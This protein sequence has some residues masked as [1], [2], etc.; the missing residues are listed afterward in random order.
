MSFADVLQELTMKYRAVLDEDAKSGKRRNGLSF[1]DKV[2]A[3]LFFDPDRVGHFAEGVPD[4]IRQRIASR[5]AQKFLRSSPSELDEL[6]AVDV[7]MKKQFREG[8]WTVL[9]LNLVDASSLARGRRQLE[10]IEQRVREALDYLGCAFIPAME[11]LC[12]DRDLGGELGCGS[13]YEYM[14]RNFH[15]LRALNGGHDHVPAEG[16]ARD[17]PTLRMKFEQL[18]EDGQRLHWSIASHDGRVRMT[19]A[20]LRKR[21]VEDTQAFLRPLRG[22]IPDPHAILRELHSYASILDVLAKAQSVGTSVFGQR[23][24][25]IRDYDNNVAKIKDRDPIHVASNPATYGKRQF[26]YASKAVNASRPSELVQPPTASCEERFTPRELALLAFIADVDPFLICTQ[27]Q[28]FW[29]E[30]WASRE[31]GAKI[32]GRRHVQEADVASIVDLLSSPIPEP[33]SSL[34]GDVAIAIHRVIHI[35]ID[36]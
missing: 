35:F 20:N 17:N 29:P 16:E 5:K 10:E 7:W 19:G 28:L 8:G 1:A 12:P 6:A 32:F 18:S 2:P 14:A 34:I 24:D 13:A 15:H 25:H 36:L 9:L 30:V 31:L 26:G 4:L 21:L 23:P 3:V 27:H 22:P 33:G 11:L